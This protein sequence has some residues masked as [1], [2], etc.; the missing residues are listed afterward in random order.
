MQTSVDQSGFSQADIP[1]ASLDADPLPLSSLPAFTHALTS[2]VVPKSSLLRRLR[3]ALGLQRRPDTGKLE[4]APIDAGVPSPKSDKDVQRDVAGLPLT[5]RRAL[6]DRGK[7]GSAAAIDA[8]RHALQGVD[9]DEEQQ[10]QRV[11]D[12]DGG[13]DLPGEVRGAEGDAASAEAAKVA[14]DAR[15]RAECSLVQC[16]QACR[17]VNS[18]QKR[19]R[20]WAVPASLMSDVED[21]GE[22]NGR[23]QVERVRTR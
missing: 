1:R 21:Q 5:S 22:K 20:S 4:V 11:V 7:Q 19:G 8:M 16:Q 3:C 14:M 23:V 17:L 13:G 12:D 10:Q 18:L 2:T 15:Q 9:V 6:K